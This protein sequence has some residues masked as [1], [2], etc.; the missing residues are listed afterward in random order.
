M[1]LY[2]RQTFAA[3]PCFFVEDPSSGGGVFI[4]WALAFQHQRH[5]NEAQGRSIRMAPRNDKIWAPV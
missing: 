4:W 2:I 1:M 5:A 3:E